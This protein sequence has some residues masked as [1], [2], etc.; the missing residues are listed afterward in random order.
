MHK[1]FHSS[2]VVRLVWPCIPEQSLRE[3]A[4][5]QRNA[6]ILGICRRTQHAFKAEIDA[7]LSEVKLAGAEIVK[8]A[9]EAFWRGYR[10]I[11]AILTATSGRS[12]GIQV[13]RSI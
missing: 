1:A 10:A 8:E 5:W 6:R 13:S 9:T 11:F 7:I 12:R 4:D 2:S 3:M